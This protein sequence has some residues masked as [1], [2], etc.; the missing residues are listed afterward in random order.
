M[1]IVFWSADNSHSGCSTSALCMALCHALQ[2]EDESDERVS[3]IQT[4]FSDFSS[5]YALFGSRVL[6]ETYFGTGMDNLLSIARSRA[7]VYED[8]YN[9]SFSL[10]DRNLLYYI[11]SRQTNREFFD[12]TLKKLP[13]LVT[14]LDEHV[15]YNYIDLC[16]C[17]D[18]VVNEI[19]SRAD[20]LVI[21]VSQN[22]LVLRQSVQMAESLVASG[23][24]KKQ[25]LRFCIG[26]YEPGSTL[27]KKNIEKKYAL[28]RHRTFV[29][30]RNIGLLDAVGTGRMNEF[31]MKNSGNMGRYKGITD[32]K[33]FFDTLRQNLEF[34][35]KGA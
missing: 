24:V 4:G 34:F 26:N 30:P 27:S 17:T 6:T 25:S 5:D 18:S 11:A 28:M 32:Q 33:E 31:F 21:H 22:D 8:A 15:D 9:S 10:A 2:I 23:A 35:E 3:F 14:E 1:K 13:E 16:C 29:V 19:L 12:Q 20:V 7:L